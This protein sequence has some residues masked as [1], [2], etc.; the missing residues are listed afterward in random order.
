MEF[1]GRVSSM[2]ERY[3]VAVNGAPFGQHLGRMS[4]IRVAWSFLGRLDVAAR[5]QA[6]VAICE[7]VTDELR[8]CW[9]P[10]SSGWVIEAAAGWL[11]GQTQF[12]VEE[13]DAT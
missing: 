4:A 6:V 2:G 10:R 1:S 3:S 11:D 5:G 12:E 9:W 13:H 8:A 7:E